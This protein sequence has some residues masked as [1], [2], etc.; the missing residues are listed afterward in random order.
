MTR[1]SN[2]L[3]N[4]IR[5]NIMK[6]LPNRDYAQE[7][8]DVVQAVILERME[9]EVRAVYDNPDL[10]GYLSTMYYSVRKGNSSVSLYANAQERLDTLY[11]LKA[12]LTIRMDDIFNVRR[13][14]DESLYKAIVTKLHDSKLVD[15][16]FQQRELRDNVTDRLRANL[17]AAKTIKQLYTVLEPEL[18][19]FIPKDEAKA[20]LPSCVAPVVD[21][22]RKLG[23]MLPNS[24]KAEV[25][26]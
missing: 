20:L 21:D 11:G 8:H 25:T 15:G 13:L 1:L 26:K 14:P 16:Y 18:H 5:T 3:R 23:A 4:T 12:S 24:P 10:R 19:H 17:D 6:G 2:D 22:L 7:I 9:P